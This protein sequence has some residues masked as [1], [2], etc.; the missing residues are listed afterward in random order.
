MIAKEKRKIRSGDDVDHLFPKPKGEDALIKRS[1]T[2]ED[3]VEFI[4][5]VVGKHW[6]TRGSSQGN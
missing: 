3:T 1:A 2:V 6:T 5:E 4:P